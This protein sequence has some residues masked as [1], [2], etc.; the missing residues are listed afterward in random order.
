[1]IFDNT[2]KTGVIMLSKISQSQ[3]DKHNMI[4]LIVESK[5]VD[6]PEF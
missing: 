4:S 6:L 5:K 3:K 2:D 1:M